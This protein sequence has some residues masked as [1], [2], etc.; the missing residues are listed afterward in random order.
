M[1]QK[2]TRW[3]FRLEQ[4]KLI[5]LWLLYYQILFSLEKER[6]E[7]LPS[8]EEFSYTSFPTS[9]KFLLGEGSQISSLESFLALSYIQCMWPIKP[10]VP[11]IG[12]VLL[13]E[14]PSDPSL[15]LLLLVPDL[16]QLSLTVLTVMRSSRRGCYIQVRMRESNSK[17]NMYLFLLICLYKIQYNTTQ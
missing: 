3:V 10:Q 8:G 17:I 5:Q 7:N 1:V 2:Y 16:M 9:E 4:T 12:N 6:R 15:S 14:P 11:V 13:G